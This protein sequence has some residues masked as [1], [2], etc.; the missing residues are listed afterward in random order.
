MPDKGTDW[1]VKFVA[2]KLARIQALNNMIQ[3]KIRKS[4]RQIALSEELAVP[5]AKIWHP[6]VPEA[7]RKFPDAGQ[8]FD[9]AQEA[10]ASAADD[11]AH[12]RP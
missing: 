4:R 2:A 1:V 12:A 3:E 8:S 10:R 5:V 6:E 9:L 11:R 7:L